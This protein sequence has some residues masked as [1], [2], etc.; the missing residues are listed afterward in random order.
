MNAVAVAISLLVAGLGALTGLA[1]AAK[2]PPN[3]F[4]VMADGPLLYDGFD[5]QSEFDLMNRSGVQTVRIAMPWSA[6]EPQPGVFDFTGT[7]AVVA[8]AAIHGFT[9]LPTVTFAP[10][11]AARHPGS[12]NS[13]PEGTDNYSNFMT[14]LVQRYGPNGGF[15]AAHPELPPH[16]IRAWQIWNEPNQPVFNWSDQ[17]FG[18]DY[19]ALLR[20]ARTAVK[21]ADPAA[22]IVL[23]GLVG[24]S[25]NALGHIYK[26]GGRN[27]FDV[28]AIHPFTLQARNVLLI[29]HKV[30]AIM[31]RFHDSRKPMYLTELTWP[32]AKG[33]R[34]TRTYGYEVNDAQQARKLGQVIPLLMDERRS[35]RLER[36]Y[37]Y[38]WISSAPE[39]RND[40]FSYSGLR[41]L[42]N[43]GT[44]VQSRPSLAVYAHM[45][46]RYE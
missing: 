14:T 1:G 4:G 41:Q 32:A 26:A 16:P 37:W 19:V 7:D 3:F 12:S 42:Q 35:L 22:K 27:L 45:A 2:V 15:W 5:E 43:N 18:S 36:V 31:A 8:Q 24:T 21:T 46:H 13:P 38:T 6:M 23:A 17:P 30:R 9:P 33:F 44:T 10:A 40:P 28:V 29:L 25:W 11:W 20:A 34:L 39:A